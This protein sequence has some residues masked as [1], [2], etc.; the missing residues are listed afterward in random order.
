MIAFFIRFFILLF[1]LASFTFNI[2]VFLLGQPSEE[3]WRFLIENRD[4][5]IPLVALIAII[6]AAFSFFYRIMDDD[7][8]KIKRKPDNTSR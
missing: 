7:C 5:D 6:A 4:F 1:L 3:T 2:L 8:C